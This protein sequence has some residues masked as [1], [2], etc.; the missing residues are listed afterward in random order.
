MIRFWIKNNLLRDWISGLRRT[1]WGTFVCFCGA[2]DHFWNGNKI[3]GNFVEVLRKYF[4]CIQ[5]PTKSSLAHKNW[6]VQE[7]LTCM[8]SGQ[9]RLWVCAHYSSHLLFCM[10][11]RYCLLF[12]KLPR[13]NVVL[14][15][16]N[17]KLVIA[18]NCRYID[19]VY[20]VIERHSKLKR[21][22]W[23]RQFLET[24]K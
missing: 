12:G 16:L 10:L 22:F 2:S 13:L 20:F 19:S 6:T 23:L 11:R 4:Y 1:T 8:R 14:Q 5:K 7:W 18:N 15:R 21:K 17:V 9:L 3:I 24:V